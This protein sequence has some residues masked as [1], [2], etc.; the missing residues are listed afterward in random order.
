MLEIFLKKLTNSTEDISNIYLGLF[1]IK[2]TDELHDMLDWLYKEYTNQ[3]FLP[4]AQQTWF[5]QFHKGIRQTDFFVGCTKTTRKSLLTPEE[6]RE[7]HK[8]ADGINAEWQKVKTTLRATNPNMS[9]YDYF[10]LTD[11]EKHKRHQE[12]KVK[13]QNEVVVS[14][15][16]DLDSVLWNIICIDA[17]QYLRLTMLRSFKEYDLEMEMLDELNQLEI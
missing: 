15:N 7:M 12:L 5:Y 16:G 4:S 1:G 2:A 8:L 9:L 10:N 13:S 14:I 11:P 17:N 3:K 6:K